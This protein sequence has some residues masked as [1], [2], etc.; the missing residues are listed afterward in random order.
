MQFMLHIF[1]INPIIDML[2]FLAILYLFICQH[3]LFTK[4]GS[5]GVSNQVKVNTK[6]FRLLESNQNET[7]TEAVRKM[8]QMSDQEWNERGVDV[9]NSGKKNEERSFSSVSNQSQ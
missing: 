1:F 6:Q 8:L 7:D 3:Q 2:T 4:K 5:E 9:N